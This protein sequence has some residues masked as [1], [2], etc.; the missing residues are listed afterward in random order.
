MKPLLSWLN[1]YRDMNGI[2]LEGKMLLRRQTLPRREV[3][4]GAQT[5]HAW[6]GSIPEVSL[7][8]RKPDHRRSASRC[9]V[10]RGGAGR[11]SRITGAPM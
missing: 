5:M 2:T 1:M 11:S 8:T 3:Y 7:I 10:Q 9:L 4:L 6:F